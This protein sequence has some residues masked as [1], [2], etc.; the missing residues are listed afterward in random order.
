MISDSKKNSLPDFIAARSDAAG[1]EG[2]RN[3]NCD[4][5]SKLSFVES[6]FGCSSRGIFVFSLVK[7]NSKF[8]F[9]LGI[10]QNRV[11]SIE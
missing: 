11:N 5:N 8:L 3:I 6:N 1:N 2:K 4:S 9:C 10:D 7:K